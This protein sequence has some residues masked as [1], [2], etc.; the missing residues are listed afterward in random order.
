MTS[1]YEGLCGYLFLNIYFSLHHPRMEQIFWIYK[2]DEVMFL[3]IQNIYHN[4]YLSL[5]PILHNKDYHTPTKS[6]HKEL[7]LLLVEDIYKLGVLKFVYKQQNNLLPNVFSQFYIENANIHSQGIFLWNSIPS[8]LRSF[9]LK[10]FS[11][12][13]SKTSSANTNHW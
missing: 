3:N 9:H 4:C 2:T 1:H 8:K 12:N 13:L 10:T 7:N 6:L 5:F 11:K